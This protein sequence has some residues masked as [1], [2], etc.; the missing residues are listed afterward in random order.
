MIQHG[1]CN[2]PMLNANT[3]TCTVSVVYGEAIIADSSGYGSTA[4][5]ARANAYREVCGQ[6]IEKIP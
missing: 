6:L 2:P 3:I 5:T 1:V 4:E